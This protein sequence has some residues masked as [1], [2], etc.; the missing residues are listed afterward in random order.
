MGNRKHLENPESLFEEYVVIAVPPETFN[1]RVVA[2]FS[3]VISNL[4]GYI[5]P[6]Y[7]VATYPEHIGMAILMP[8]AKFQTFLNRL[9]KGNPIADCVFYTHQGKIVSPKRRRN[10]L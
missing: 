8:T 4:G 3:K 6:S 5:M 2:Y 7:P 9:Q 1:M 10:V